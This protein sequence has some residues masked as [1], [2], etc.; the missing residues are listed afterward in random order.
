LALEVEE[1]DLA[2]P[3][4]ER[5]VGSVLLEVEEARRAKDV[6]SVPAVDN[7]EL[8]KGEGLEISVEV[9]GG[10]MEF[11]AKD[12][13]GMRPRKRARLDNKRVWCRHLE[14]GLCSERTAI[15]KRNAEKL[16]SQVE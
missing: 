15:E 6:A 16:Q 11:C 13:I 10:E 2:L 5:V 14:H 1:E 4:D 3:S 9:V 8:S 7:A 12:G